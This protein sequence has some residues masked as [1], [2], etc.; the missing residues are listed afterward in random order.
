MYESDNYGTYIRTFSS[1]DPENHETHQQMYQ[2]LHSKPIDYS[3]QTL[4]YNSL[5]LVFVYFWMLYSRLTF[6][7]FIFEDCILLRLLLEYFGG[8]VNRNSIFPEYVLLLLHTH[9]MFRPLR[10][11]F[12]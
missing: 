6:M 7:I 12:K 4:L 11:I 8:A 9:Y 2:P 1:H 3:Y 10:A 5:L